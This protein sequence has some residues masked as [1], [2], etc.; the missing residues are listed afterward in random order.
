MLDQ[1]DDSTRREGDE[2]RIGKGYPEPH[3]D[4]I[5]HVRQPDTREKRDDPTG[6]ERIPFS[7]ERETDRSEAEKR[8]VQ[9]PTQRND[10]GRVFLRIESRGP[11]PA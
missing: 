10:P 6:N 3:Y 2:Q 7:I 4:L 11:E 8:Q 9:D 5:R 1:R